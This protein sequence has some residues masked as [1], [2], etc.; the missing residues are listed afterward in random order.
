MQRAAPGTL[1]NHL[2]ACDAYQAATPAVPAVV[3]AGAKDRLVSPDLCEQLA[4]RL[5]ARYELIPDTGHQI[6]WERPA[7]IIE[8]VTSLFEPKYVF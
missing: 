2:K 7:R 5:G 4:E 1:T 6:P 8:A 3:L